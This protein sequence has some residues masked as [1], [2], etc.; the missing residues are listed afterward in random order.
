MLAVDGD[1]WCLVILVMLIH[2]CN[3]VCW[4]EGEGGRAGI[5]VN[6]LSPL[7]LLGCDEGAI[8]P[9]SYRY[10]WVLLFAVCLLSSYIAVVGGRL[11]KDHISPY[12]TRLPM[13]LD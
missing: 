5:E 11:D 12:H 2:G 9:P 8:S 4:A 1:A 3:R 7:L 10:R 13:M 6:R